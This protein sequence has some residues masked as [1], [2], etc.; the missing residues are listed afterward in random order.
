MR[1]ITL[2]NLWKRVGAR[3]IDFILNIGLTCALFFGV[4]YQATFNQ[5]LYQP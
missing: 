2:G 4:V 5:S 1:Y 3:L